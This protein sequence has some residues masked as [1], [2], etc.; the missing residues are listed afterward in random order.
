MSNYAAVIA[1]LAI[2]GSRTSTGAVN[3]SGKVW[4]YQLGTSTTVQMYADAAATIPVTQPITLDAGGRIPAADYPDGVFI[5]QPVRL[6]IQD[7]AGGTVSDTDYIPSTA[8]ATGLNNDGWSDSTVDGAFSKLFTS[9][10]GTDG[11]YKRAKGATARL[12]KAKLNDIGFSPLDYGAAGNGIAVDTTAVQAAINAAVAAGGG[13]VDLGPYDYKIDGAL[14]FPASTGVS[15]VGAGRGAT[16]ITTTSGSANVFAMSSCTSASL[17]GF[18]V[19][20]AGA[21]TGKI[22]SA[23]NCPNMLVDDVVGGAVGADFTYGIDASGTTSVNVFRSY[24]RGSTKSVRY[25]VNGAPAEGSAVYDSRLVGD[26]EYL[27]GA[28]N[29]KLIGNTITGS[30]L[31]STGLTGSVFTFIGNSGATAITVATTLTDPRIRQWGNNLD[32]N[33]TSSATGATQTPVFANGAKHI[34]ITATTSGAGTVTIAA[35]AVMPVFG[36]ANNVWYMHFINA[37][38][39]AVTWDVTTATVYKFDAAVPTTNAHT[40]TVIVY[41]DGTNIREM[42]RADTVT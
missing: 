37:S 9:L 23:A 4:A 6:L 36:D 42:G 3:D 15:I 38:G 27:D 39:N 40:V 11:T 20:A 34:N 19:A 18:T 24:L 21:S 12:V 2:S 7:S 17:R 14:S 29:C 8:G 22:I 25:N 28:S 16:T 10:G 41:F 13:K 5:T 33:S 31:L 26:I 35:P 32:Y 30:I 1:P